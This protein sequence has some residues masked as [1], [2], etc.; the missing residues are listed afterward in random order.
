MDD[1]TLA[2]MFVANKKLMYAIPG[3]IACSLALKLLKH[4]KSHGGGL[5]VGA[6]GHSLDVGQDT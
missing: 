1:L 6:L 3:I 2:I 5:M 4:R